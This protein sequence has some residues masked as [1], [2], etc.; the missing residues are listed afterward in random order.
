MISTRFVLWLCSAGLMMMG[1]SA[2]CQE[3][4]TRP[5]RILTSGVGGSS[6]FAS[7]Q[8]AQG[9]TESLKQQVIV[10]NRGR[11]GIDI[12]VKSSP[13]GYNLLLDGASF[14]ITPLVQETNYDPV[15]DFAPITA[16]T[17][18]HYIIVVNPSLPVKSIKELIALAKAKPGTLNYSASVAVGAG[19]ANRLSAELFRSMAGVDLVVVNYT[20]GAAT[21]IT[22]VIGGEVHLSFATAPAVAPHIK[23]GGRLRALA[24]SS[25]QRDPTFPDLPTTSEAGVPGYEWI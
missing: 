8:I 4:P 21:A 14:W 20:G 3:F 5:I 18:T 17:K 19:S 15:K 25:L 6:D 9:L 13:D 11:A 2:V 12:M 10:D 16:A 22:A 23:A 24:I 1:A 7:R